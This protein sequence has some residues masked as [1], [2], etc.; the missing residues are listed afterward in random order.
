M[1][2][3]TLRYATVSI[4][5]RPNSV[6][7]S[8]ERVISCGSLQDIGYMDNETI[9]TASTVIEADPERR[10]TLDMA[11][12]RDTVCDTKYLASEI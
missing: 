2:T 10:R 7:Q 8:L 12:F 5:P 6:L 4:E 11:A 3:I 1:S 9:G